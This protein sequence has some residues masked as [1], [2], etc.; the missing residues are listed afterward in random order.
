MIDKDL[1]YT[2]AH[3]GQFKLSANSPGGDNDVEVVAAVEFDEYA[4]ILIEV[5]E[6]CCITIGARELH[7]MATALD[8][9]T[10]EMQLARDEA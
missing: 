10:E 6:P 1:A 8:M 3:D 5:T 2:L 9:V 7:G 4:T